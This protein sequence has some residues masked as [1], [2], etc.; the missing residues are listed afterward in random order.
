MPL[1]ALLF[2]IS[3][4]GNSTS[5][6]YILLFRPIKLVIGLPA[7]SSLNYFFILIKIKFRG[8]RVIAIVKHIFMIV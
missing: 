5:Y 2:F 3:P 4:L 1:H 7:A 8:F 6:E